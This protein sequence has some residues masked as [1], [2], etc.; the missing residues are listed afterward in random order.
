VEGEHGGREWERMRACADVDADAEA[1]GE[2][3]M[4][5]WR[6]KAKTRRGTCTD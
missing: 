6:D 4:K 5:G 3:E 2:N 1:R